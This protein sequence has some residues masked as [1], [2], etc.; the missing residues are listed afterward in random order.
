M[1]RYD[2]IIAGG[3]MAGLSLAYYLSQSPLRDRSILILDKENKSRNDRTWCFWEE[4]PGP[5]EPILYRKWN[6]VEFFGTTYQGLLDIG[7]YQYKML[8][9]IDFYDHLKHHLAQFPS[10]E[11]R[12]ATVNRVKDTPQGGFVIADDEPYMADYVFDST[13]ALKLD[14]PEN[15]NLLQHFKGWTITTEKPC[16]DPTR[17]CMMDFRVEQHNDCRFV[18]IL[19]FDERTALVEYTIFND[20]LLS[21]EEYETALRGYI[22]RFLDTGTYT[23]QEKEFGVIPMS[24]EPTTERAGRHV[25]RIGTSGGYTKPSTGYTFQRT[26]RYL[27][28]IVQNLVRNGKPKRRKSWFRQGF[29]MYM[30]S[31]L[32]NVLQYHRHPADDVFT[33]LYQNNAPAQIFRFLDEDTTFAE[34]LKIMTTV[35]MGAFTIAAFDVIRK[36]VIRA[37]PDGIRP[38]NKH[39]LPGK[40]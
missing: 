27:H 25:V 38:R 29:K 2:F 8:R 21:D 37:Y 23:I 40:A 35:P 5:F 16:F 39:W 7:T 20:Q 32:L 19:P 28:E 31:V 4:Q 15:H 12:Q 22:D 34:D 18:Y 1:K 33:R 24:D 36:R 6:T 26:Q 14:Q 13:H 17:P 3:G 11:I 10:I 30:D 9:G